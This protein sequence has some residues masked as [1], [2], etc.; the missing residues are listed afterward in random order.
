MSQNIL[1]K[2]IAFAAAAALTGISLTG[3][4]SS[5]AA[6]SSAASSASAA[7]VTSDA[8]GT[9]GGAS[10]NASAADTA[11]AAAGAKTVV[12]A[13][14]SGSPRPY[15]YVDDNNNPTGYDIEVLKKVFEQLPQYDLQIEVAQIDAV[16]SGVT[17]GQYQ[18][19]VNNFSYNDERAKSYLY[20]YPYDKISYEFVYRADA[21]PITTWE[22]AAGK[23]TEAQTGFG[24]ANA[25]EQWN[26][27]NPDKKINLNYT[28]ADTLVT[29]QHIEDGTDEFTI[30]DTAMYNNYVK[31]YGLEDLKASPLSE[32]D[33]KQISSSTYAYFLFGLD[34]SQLRDDVDGVIKKL[35]ADG[36]LT[37]LGKQYQD[38]DDCAPEDDQYTSTLN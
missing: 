35:Q 13:V 33:A 17:S 37:E 29:L 23:T 30:M 10:G 1:K 25:I 22:D 12:K 18:I 5:P 24:I 16:F 8:A 28:D 9:E 20:S 7:S 32:E 11:S 26:A 31:E 3:C 2:T 38:R 36:T 14:T 4:G 15:V 21:D 34:N 6:S 27:A 19:A